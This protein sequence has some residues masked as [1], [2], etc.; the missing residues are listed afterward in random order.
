MS[1]DDQRGAE[2]RVLELCDMDYERAAA[3]VAA[4]D[5]LRAE[6][7]ETQEASRSVIATER[8]YRRRAEAELAKTRAAGDALAA[9]MWRYAAGFTEREWFDVHPALDRWRSARGDTPTEPPADDTAAPD[10]MSLDRF[11][12]MPREQARAWIEER[13]AERQRQRE[14]ECDANG[15]HLVL[16]AD[17]SH[18]GHCGRLYA[19]IAGGSS[20]ASTDREQ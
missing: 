5:R 15:R 14:A 17:T 10:G 1:A 7:A 3:T 4:F 13:Q 8:G 2:E 19:D 18:C 16:E 20:P 11:A 6:L 9:V 12:A